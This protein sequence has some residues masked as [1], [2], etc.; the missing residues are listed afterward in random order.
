MKEK[1]IKALQMYIKVQ[2][3]NQEN[4]KLYYAFHVFK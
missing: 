2:E 4:Y 1:F 3:H